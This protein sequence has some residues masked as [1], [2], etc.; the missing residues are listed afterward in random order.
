MVE[1]SAPRPK[2]FAYCMRDF[3]RTLCPIYLI[4]DFSGVTTNQLQL[5]QLHSKHTSTTE[6]FTCEQAP[7]LW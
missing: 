6:A 2:W 1:W 3:L 4:I 5:Q 7:Q